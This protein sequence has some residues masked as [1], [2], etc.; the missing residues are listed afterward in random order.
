MFGHGVA[1]AVT[2]GPA[3]SGLGTFEKV[4][5]LFEPP[6]EVGPVY[7]SH[8]HNDYLELAVEMGLPGIVLMLLFLAWWG[9]TAWQVGRSHAF[10]QYA[11]AGVIST[12]TILIHSAV[13]FPLRTAAVSG[14]FAAGI[15]LMIVSRRRIDDK[16]DLRPTRHLVIN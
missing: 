14:L 7:I 4:Y 15:A 5:R 9:R 3:G 6:S 12:A 16:T 2:F 11:A 1:A 8:A 10:D 13:D